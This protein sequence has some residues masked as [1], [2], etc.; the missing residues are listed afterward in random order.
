MSLQRVGDGL[1]GTGQK[2]WKSLPLKVARRTTLRVG[3]KALTETYSLYK[4]HPAM[5]RMTATNYQ[6][7]MGDFARRHAW[8]TCQLASLHVPAYRDFL[9]Q[10]G[11][12][13]RWW[14]LTNYPPTSKDSYVTQYP[15]DQRCWHGDLALRGTLVDESSGSSG[16]PFNWVRGRDEL[17][18][19]HRNVAGFTSLMMREEE[20]LFVIN[21]YSMGA[22]ATGTNTGIAMA[23]IAMVKNTGPDLDKIVDTIH[24]FGPGF[25]YLVTAYPPFLKDL[26]DRLDADGLDWSQYRMHGLVGGEGM[27]EALR[28]YCEERFLTVRSGYGASDLTIGIGGE[29]ELTVWLRR[30][31][32]ED[33]G[34]REA[35]LG[36]DETRTPMVFQYNPLE[37]YLETTSDGEILCTLTSTQVLSPKLRYNIG[38]EGVLLDWHDLAAILRRNPRWR[39]EARAAWEKQG[40]KLPLLLLFGRKDAT[41][42]FMGANIY[43]QDVEN[44]LYDDSSR[45]ARLAS[46]TLTLEERDGGKD[47]QPVIHLELREGVTLAEAERADLAADARTGVVGYL[48]RVSRDF[49]QSLEESDRTGDIEVRVHDHGTGPFAAENTKLKR[50]YLQKDPS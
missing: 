16:T 3:T 12:T 26:R 1:H 15:E 19:I 22:W 17:A 20:R 47:S 39:A 37:T 45:A 14:D 10:R 5:W 44:G 18:D 33:P 49:A 46:F 8:M 24:H 23:K 25:T 11:W 32:L 28:D 36:A 29:T 13:F 42:S 6:P 50:V 34:L 7:W 30:A 41:I 9:K 40:M 43:P 38:D 31:L 4:V 21:A 27:T 2:V 35:V 48:A